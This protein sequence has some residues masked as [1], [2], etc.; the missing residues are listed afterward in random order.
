MATGN[1][2]SAQVLP[3]FYGFI[4]YN[5]VGAGTVPALN[6]LIWGYI[7]SAAQAT[8]NQPFRPESQQDADDK[9]GRGSDLARAYA[10][11]ASQPE[12]QGADIQ[13]MPI[14]APTGGVASTY[15]LKVFVPGV[16]PTKA[17]TLQ[18]WIASRPVPAVGFD[19]TDTA[20]TI[21]AALKTAIDSVL[22][23][24]IASTSIIADTITIN[25]RHKGTTGEDFPVRCNI[26]PNSPGVKLS[27]GQMTV[28]VAAVGAGSVR[29]STGSLSVS[30]ALAGGEAAVAVAT[31]VA[32]SWNADSYPLT[33]DTA[34]AVVNFY[35][36]NDKD[37]RRMS[38]AVISTTGT[39]VNL[40]S[41]ATDG[42]GSALSLTYNG[43]QG[44]GAPSL[45][46]ALTNLD[47][48]GP[49]RSWSAPW[50][51]VVTVGALA[52]KIETA[53]D[54]SITGQKMQHLTIC[55]TGTSSS[56]G[57]IAT[58]TSPNLTTSAPHY[59]IGWAPDAAVQGHE[60]AARAAAARAAFWLDTPQFNWNGFQLKGSE[61]AP[62]LLSATRPSPGALNTALRTYALAPFTPGASGNTEVI[63]GRTTSLANDKRLWAWST[64]A[65]AAFHKTDLGSRFQERFQGASIVR[66]SEPRAPGIFDAASFTATT[67]E[68]MRE[69]EALG[70]YDGAL[71]LADAVQSTPDVN[72]PFRINVTYPE[73]PVLD[74]DQVV[75]TGRFS[76]PST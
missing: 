39:T 3:G 8:P 58:G 43:T 37:V 67:Q 28:A 71:A 62:L 50:L 66:F 57:A 69:W 29:V 55:A 10:A 17:G 11:A 65:Q 47:A 64:E 4:D 15:T 7:S 40:G 36:A 53:S 41:G 13:L 19:T 74:L 21:A 52:T 61:S 30:T 76:S 6:Q 34:A 31:A 1:L 60:L 68:A 5:T 54:G 26:S 42:T 49:F 25:Y 27:P 73:S 35:F 33:A 38:A 63:K 56:A 23:L 32:A 14:V 70:N 12:S 75:F 44:T 59:A 48:L 24:P 72:N 20:S 2:T 22:D 51:D 9:C 16:N 45:T 18:I 46:S